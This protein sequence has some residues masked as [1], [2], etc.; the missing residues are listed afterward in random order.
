MPAIL[1]LWRKEFKIIIFWCN[2][3]HAIIEWFVLC[4]VGAS[5]RCYLGVSDSHLLLSPARIGA[6]RRRHVS[7]P[8]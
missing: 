1:G 3:A 5:R 7:N 2:F 6:T 8:V 4:S